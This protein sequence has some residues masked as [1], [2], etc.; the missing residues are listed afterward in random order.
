MLK[1][2]VFNETIREEFTP[3]PE[4]TLSIMERRVRSD[5]ITASG[6][7]NIFEGYSG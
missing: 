3:F 1:L 5:E 4:E 7:Q 2:E 6:S